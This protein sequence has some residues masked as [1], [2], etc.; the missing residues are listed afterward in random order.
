MAINVSFCWTTLWSATCSTLEISVIST[1]QSR[2]PLAEAFENLVERRFTTSGE[3]MVDRNQ[4][5]QELRLWWDNE[6]VVNE[7]KE[8]K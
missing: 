4:K 8:E 1:G 3:L 7:A 5:E 2:S 6:G